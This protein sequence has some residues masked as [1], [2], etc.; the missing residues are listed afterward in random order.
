MSWFL[1]D[2]YTLDGITG[3]VFTV[4][5]TTRIRSAG[6]LLWQI[7]TYKMGVNSFGG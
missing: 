4:V 3:G 2:R 1:A 6:Q 7:S 5:N